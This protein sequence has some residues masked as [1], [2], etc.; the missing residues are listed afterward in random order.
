[1]ISR[2]SILAATACAP[3]G[4]I[5]GCKNV[6]AVPTLA[7]DAQ[8]VLSGAQALGD[9]VMQLANVPA[10]T[11]TTVNNYVATIT[12]GCQAVAA[13]TPGAAGSAVSQVVSAIQAVV[14]IALPLL[15]GGSALVPVANALLSMVQPLLAY[16]GISGAS[17]AVPADDAKSVAAVYTP[18]QARLILRTAR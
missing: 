11:V 12:K 9:A 3:V 2:R 7:S 4:A 15:P 8:L 1:M 13:G 5:V 10:V 14:P 6:P 17:A 18:D 16:V